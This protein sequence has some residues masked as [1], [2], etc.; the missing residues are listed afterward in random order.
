MDRVIT[1]VLLTVLLAGCSSTQKI[2][3]P[4]DGVTVI[5]YGAGR[6]GTYILQ[7]EDGKYII[8]SEPSPDVAQEIT[9]SLGLSAGTFGE[10]VDP[11]LKAAYANKVVDLASRGQTLQIL[12]ESLFRLSEMGASSDIDIDQRVALYIKVLDTVRLIAATEFGQKSGASQEVIDAEL[13]R[14][15]SGTSSGTVTIPNN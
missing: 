12:R 5:D 11:E 7:T 8:V 4:K 10:L 2:H 3:V 6:R 13:T 1:V 15:L 9:A 14:F